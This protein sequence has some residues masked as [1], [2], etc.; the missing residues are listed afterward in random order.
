MFTSYTIEEAKGIIGGKE[1]YALGTEV[2]N[3]E[4]SYGRIV[5]RDVVS[6]CN[7]PGF[8]RSIMDGYAVKHV[9]IRKACKDVPVLLRL[10]G[11]V[12]MGKETKI[13]VG[14]GECVYIPTGGMLPMGADSVL[15]IENT[16]RE[17]NNV[18]AYE[19]TVFGENVVSEDEDVKNG[20]LLIPKGKKIRP[21]E[22]GV[23]SSIGY[24]NIE[25]YKKARIGILTTGDEI[26][27]P[28]EIPKIGQVR[29]V[30]TYLLS[31]LIGASNCE[32]VIYNAQ[33][34]NY[35]AIYREAKKVIEECDIALICGGSSVGIKDHTLRVLMSMEETEILFH[36][37]ALKP[38]KPTIVAKCGSKMVFG[39]PGHPLSCAVV[40]KT[41][42]EFYLNHIMEHKA[43]EYPIY[44]ELAADY[45][46]TKG[47]EEYIPVTVEEI[48]GKFYATP[49]VGRS[50]IITT[51]SKSYGYFKTPKELD[52]V[53]K[54]DVVGIYKL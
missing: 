44:C 53:L 1:K 50:G 31:G 23:L 13:E 4:N 17:G 7:V 20:E 52:K 34:D 9:D 15:I 51:F 3:I 5:A 40:Y 10:V 41:L 33:V 25:V 12:E 32:V 27:S 24:T 30:N 18:V 19:K 47:R 49:V 39:M 45:K 48:D 26:V 6:E 35:D 11:E 43:V 2:V 14:E 22:M 54:G 28:Y 46:K 16:K 8:K 29:D 21:Y 37:L 36:G 38:G 42:V